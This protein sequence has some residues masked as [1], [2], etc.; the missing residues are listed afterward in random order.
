MT[1]TYGSVLN[2]DGDETNP[3]L[4]TLPRKVVRKLEKEAAEGR[5]AAAKLQE[6]EAR[7]AFR[8][9][10]VDLN[11]P[12]AAYFVR[13]YSGEKTKEAI[14]AEWSRAFGG[15][16]GGQQDQN[17]QQIEQELQAQQGGQ[18]L[19][20]GQGSPTQ[21]KLAERDAKLRDLSP[22]DP[23]FPQKFDAIAREY[24]TVYGDM[25]G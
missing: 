13:G 25:I 24:G 4:A 10:G 21:D 3:K 9:A 8:E 1:D 7:E 14:Q 2:E 18:S 12:A 15:A 22:T 6:Y 19:V 16:S 17:Q 11:N 20:G 23:F 5:E